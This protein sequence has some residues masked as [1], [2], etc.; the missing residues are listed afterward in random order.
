MAGAGGAVAVHDRHFAYAASP[1]QR[2]AT[3]CERERG[4][5]EIR[6]EAPNPAMLPGYAAALRTGWSPN[7]VRD[8][9]GEQLAAIEADAAAFL[10]GTVW[11]PDSVVALGDGT[12][13]PRLPD[14]QFWIVDG[15]FCGSINLR[16]LPG[17][18]DLP[19][20]V[21]GHVGY[22]VVPWKRRMGV[23]TQALRLVLPVARSVGLPRVMV[24]TAPDNLV[25]QRVIAAAGGQPG[26]RLAA[27]EGHPEEMVFWIDTA[28]GGGG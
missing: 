14:R 20:H 26:G 11:T 27:R 13:R 7:N 18:T 22:A 12:T 28:G 24:T 2:C 15:E 25:S 16:Y 9:S 23:A 8:V 3:D 19:P 6:L 1:L 4:V 10:A 5:S 21:L 17:T